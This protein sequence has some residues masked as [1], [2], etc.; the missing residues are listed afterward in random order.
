MYIYIRNYF[1]MEG[2]HNSTSNS[3]MK[4]LDIEVES[5]ADS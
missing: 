2:K 3:N 5:L 4:T 1:Y